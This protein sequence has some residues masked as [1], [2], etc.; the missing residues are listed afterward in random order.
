MPNRP[1]LFV[2]VLVAAVAIPYVLLDKNLSQTAR[3]Q[4]DRISGRARSMAGGPKSEAGAAA[5]P[6]ETP[7]VVEAIPPAAPIE[8]VFRFEITPQWVTS[9]WPRVSTAPGDFDL[10]GMRVAYAS[11]TQPHDVVGSLTYYFNKHHQ[12]E[13]IT[14][15]GLTGDHRRLMSVLVGSYRLK[16]QPTTGIA[17]YIAGDP[18]KPTSQISVRHT[19]TIVAGADQARAELLVDL[20]RADLLN[21]RERQEDPE[22]DRK[23]LPTSYRRW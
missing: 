21:P 4:L 6:T 9:R 14:F 2:G 1:L 15:T 3:S 5:G 23:F 16:S 22:A 18:A 11:G 8:E 20:R 12:L 19:P 13:R 10:L 7:Q 17:N